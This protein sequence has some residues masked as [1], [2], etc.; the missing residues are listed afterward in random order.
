MAG[1]HGLEHVEVAP[2]RTSPTMMVV[3]TYT[4]RVPDELADRDGPPTFDVG[5]ARLQ[6]QHVVLVEL[7]LCG[8]LDR[9][10]ALIPGRNELRT[11]RVVVFPEPVPPEM[12]MLRRP[13]TQAS[14]KSR[15]WRTW[16]RRRSGHDR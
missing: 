2:S 11:L 13:R 4:Q 9:D 14:R 8:V 15:T 3:R 12:M 16:C 1:V 6:P 7:E 5:R 10:D